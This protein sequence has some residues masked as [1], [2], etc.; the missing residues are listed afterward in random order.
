M[1]QITLNSDY[2]EQL[3]CQRDTYSKQ[4]D[5]ILDNYCGCIECTEFRRDSE[6]FNELNSL[7][8]SIMNDIEALEKQNKAH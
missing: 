4:S 5:D 8:L 1:D 2:L 6:K 7:I 3:K